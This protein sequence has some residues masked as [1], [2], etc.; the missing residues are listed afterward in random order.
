MC[1]LYPRYVSDV[2]V[3]LGADDTQLEGDSVGE[4]AVLTAI[5]DLEG[6]GH[7]IITDNF[8]TS[9]RL[10]MELLKHGFWATGGSCRKSRKGFPP[11]LASFPKTQLPERGHLV[12][13]MH[14]SCRIT[15]ICWMDAKP[16]FFLSTACNPIGEGSYAGC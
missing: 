1:M 14:H 6:R 15:A 9:P 7:V 11:S 16:V 13:K 2:I 8:F 3:Y 4:D 12:L 10:F 5:S